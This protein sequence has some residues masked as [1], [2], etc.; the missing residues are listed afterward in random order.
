MTYI[1]TSLS[2]KTSSAMLIVILAGWCFYIAKLSVIMLNV[3]KNK[4]IMLTVVMLSA[5]TPK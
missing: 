1:I 3:V 5:V 2:I 4:D